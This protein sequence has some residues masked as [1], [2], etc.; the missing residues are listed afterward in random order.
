MAMRRNMTGRP[1]PATGVDRTLA[2]MME[3]FHGQS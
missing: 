3:A 2:R 1:S